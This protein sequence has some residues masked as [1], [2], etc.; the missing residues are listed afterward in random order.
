MPTS[1]PLLA[2]LTRLIDDCRTV[3]AQPG[4]KAEASLY[5]QFERFMHDSFDVLRPQAPPADRYLFLQQANAEQTG[6]PDFRVQQRQELQGWVEVKAVVGKNLNHL[7]GHDDN[8]LQRFRN[9]LDNV[10]F[11]TG[12][13]WRLYQ[14]GQQVGR[15][16]VLGPDGTFDPNQ[17]RYAVSD[18]AVAELRS[19]LASFLAAPSQSYVSAQAAVT[20]LAAR[21]KSLKIALVEVG[22]TGAGTNLIQLS[23]D[24]KALLYRNGLPF[25]WERFVDSYVQ[26]ATFGALLWRLE[27]GQSIS[28]AQQVGVSQGLH[29]LLAQC[30]AI[31]WSPAARTPIFE[32]LLEELC[33]SVN[34]IN[35]K[36]FA[37]KAAT[38]KGKRRYIP[39]PIVHAYEPFFQAYDPATR[40]TSGVYYTPVEI[41]EHIVDGV[42]DVMRGTLQR[43]DGL[44]DPDAKFLDPATGTGTFLLGLAP[45]FQDE[46]DGL[47]TG[48]C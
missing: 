2:P 29:P 21:A 8:Q 12:W 1:D 3:L 16:V 26:L 19:L 31:M 37:P 45:V 43:P 32:P 4:T 47:I 36:Q 6:I 18:A 41:V 9:G 40:E 7:Q 24:F 33:R 34:N 44:L 17:M 25:T 27:T 39:D 14:H 30:L 22:S 10:I 20:A 15:D 13:Q 5:T 28:L 11:T 48:G 35:P 46:F 38:G 23:D 42:S